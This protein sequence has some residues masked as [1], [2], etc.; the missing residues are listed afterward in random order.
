[1]AIEIV[2]DRHT[3]WQLKLFLVAMPYG[4]RRIQ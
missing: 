3:L 1:M 2:F 4:R